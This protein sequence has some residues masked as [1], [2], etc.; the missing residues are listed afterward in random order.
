VIA[1]IYPALWS[2]SLPNDGRDGHQQDA[3]SIARWMRER[4]NAGELC[5]EFQQTLGLH[6][7]AVAELEGWIL[8]VA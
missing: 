4:D 5:V 2:K 8:G 3:Y 6:E 1:E 7:R